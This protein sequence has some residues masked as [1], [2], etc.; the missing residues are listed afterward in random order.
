V[1]EER[2]KQVNE[3]RKGG[4]VM[5]HQQCNKKK[6]KEKEVKEEARY[7]RNKGRQ[8]NTCPRTCKHLV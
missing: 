3:K 6:A 8:I 5:N 4:I 1:E 7:G 2:L